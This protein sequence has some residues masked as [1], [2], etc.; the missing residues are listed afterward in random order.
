MIHNLI[1]GFFLTITIEN[2]YVDYISMEA[3][4]ILVFSMKIK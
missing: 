3:K 1:L 4:N 2:L